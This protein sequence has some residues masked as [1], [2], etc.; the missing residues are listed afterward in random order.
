[1]PLTKVSNNK[2]KTI[3]LFYVDL[4]LIV[5]ILTNERKD[6]N[7]NIINFWEEGLEGCNRTERGITWT[8]CN[9]YNEKFDVYG[10]HNQKRIKES[11]HYTFGILIK[12]MKSIQFDIQPGNGY[13]SMELDNLR[14][15]AVRKYTQNYVAY[16]VLVIIFSKKNVPF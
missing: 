16:V 2:V 13:I 5:V 12:L 4:Y 7:H 9:K 3:P 14:R 6:H 1:M 8:R 10:L 11:A 15:T